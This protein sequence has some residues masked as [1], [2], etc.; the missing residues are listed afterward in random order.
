M[1]AKSKNTSQPKETTNKSV[2]AR[3]EDNSIQLTLT[4]PN[5]LVQARKEE[6]LATLAEKLNIPGFRK[7]KAPRELAEKRID[8][9]DL[10][11][12]M[13]SHLLP[14]VYAEAVEEHHVRPI[15][16]PRFE[17]LSISE[18]NDWTVRAI[19]CELPFVEVGDY[20]G[21][22]KGEL[23]TAKIWRPGKDG[24]REKQ[25]AAPEEKEQ[26]ILE[27]I[28][29]NTKSQIPNVLI[30]EE[31]NHKLSRLLDQTQKLGLTVEQYLVST[32]KTIEG[33][34]TELAQQAR[35]A[36]MLELALNKI[37]D[38]EKIL[39]DETEINQIIRASGSEEQ[40][41]NATPQQKVM[42]SG[43]IKRRKALDRL[44]NI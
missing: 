14:E 41:Q 1:A 42:I 22:I 23:Q 10:Y 21:F 8:K 5:E 38:E 37:A 33:L 12:E 19:T 15:L 18:G 26:K 9:Q 34:R 40:A 11:N 13:L 17:I 30:E 43:V 35:E 28:I 4:I 36:I 31:V 2:L 39:V 6:A 27:V 32:G 16:A 20:K 3:T 24:E 29:K 25:E 7:G 44:A